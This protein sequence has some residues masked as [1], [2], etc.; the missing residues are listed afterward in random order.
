MRQLRIVALFLAAGFALRLD[1]SYP[2]SG[3]KYVQGVGQ[4]TFLSLAAL[5]HVF[6]SYGGSGGSPLFG[7]D[8]AVLAEAAFARYANCRNASNYSNRAVTNAVS[9]A[10]INRIADAIDNCFTN[11][12]GHLSWVVG[13]LNT[14]SRVVSN[15]SYVDE[16]RSAIDYLKN[17]GVSFYGKFYDVVS[18]SQWNA[19]SS[20][21]AVAKSKVLA[22]YNALYKMK[23]CIVEPATWSAPSYNSTVVVQDKGT[24]GSTA[25]YAFVNPWLSGRLAYLNMSFIAIQETIEGEK[26]VPYRWHIRKTAGIPG[27]CTYRNYAWRCTNSDYVYLFRVQRHTMNWTTRSASDQTAYYLHFGTSPDYSQ[28]I[29][30]CGISDNVQCPSSAD[31]GYSFYNKGSAD[32]TC[33]DCIASFTY[34][35]M[36]DDY[37]Y[38]SPY[39]YTSN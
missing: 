21:D 30:E 24:P 32:Y 22:L 39:W 6:N 11:D 28:I 17:I 18:T 16:S 31:L 20:G 25:G 27:F 37:V 34:T 12:L 10:Q 29:Q 35:T 7:E 38:W 2:S 1:A 3:Y 36:K 14:N 9:A 19:V 13:S 8:V 5:Q 15:I 33:V 23:N 26:S 4:N